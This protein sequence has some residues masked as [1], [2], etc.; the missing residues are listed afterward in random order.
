MHAGTPFSRKPCV[1]VVGLSARMLAQSAVRAGFEPVALDIFG[2]RDT[3]EEASA[4]FDIGGEGLL[5]DRELLLDALQ[6][7]ARLPRMLGYVATSGVEP[8][9]G[10]LYSGERL[11]RFIGNDV[12]ATAAVRDPKRFFALL[13][14]CGIAHPEISFTRP[15]DPRRWLVKH[16][17]GCG[18]VHIEAASSESEIGPHA[19]YQRV[20][21]GRSMSALF[22]GARREACVTGFA[23][24]SSVAAGKLP[25]VHSGSL[26][27]VDLPLPVAAKLHEAIR[28]IV[29]R[30]G[31]T[32][33]NS[34]DF[35]LDGDAFSVLEINA[36]PSSTMAL[37]E[38]VWPQSLFACHVDACLHGRLPSPPPAPT[39]R[40]GQRVA[41]APFS[42]TASKPFS[43]A[44][45]GDPACHDVPL[46]GT[47]IEA[48]QPVCTLA[49]TA[50]SL[51][52]VQHELE[53]HHARLLQRIETCR[54]PLHDVNTFR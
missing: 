29:W 48:G 50:P 13:D 19:Y 52:A 46:P 10:A 21:A 51:D 47:R 6:R 35:L 18:G 8:L 20:A 45:H 41:F 17:D 53:R 2:D 30:T 25:F 3:R 15:A 24:Q 11:P 4:W 9:M 27:P 37:Y 38:A 42:I 31:L 5:I 36:R 40:A 23:D 32:G 34:M 28:A 44:L 43:D 16:A 7:A 54:E 14:E 26:G 22:V 33:I 39:R 12:A 1:A 49:V